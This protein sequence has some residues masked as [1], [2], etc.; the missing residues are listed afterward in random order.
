MNDMLSQSLVSVCR[1]IKSGE[2]TASE[3]T[4]AQLARI[5]ECDSTLKSYARVLTEEALAQAEALDEAQAAGKPLGLLHGVPIAIK[6]LIYTQ[7]IPTA[8][9]PW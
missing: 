1:R 4:R 7:G 9:A 8:S 5:E 2:L 3:V 6:D